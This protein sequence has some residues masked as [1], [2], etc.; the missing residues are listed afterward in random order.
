MASASEPPDDDFGVR[1]EWPG[2]R[3]S[4]PFIAPVSSDSATIDDDEDLVSGAKPRLVSARP[5]PPAPPDPTT[6][7]SFV[8][9]LE[10]L[11]TPRL[12]ESAS[13]VAML[14]A[15]VGRVD[16]LTAATLTFRE[17]AAQRVQHQASHVENLIGD[18]STDL[19]AGQ[20]RQDG[21]LREV[22]S[23][24]EQVVASQDRLAE[25][26]DDL[27]YRLATLTEETAAG[28]ARVA[29]D[30]QAIRRRTPIRARTGSSTADDV[31]AMADASSAAGD[32][33]LHGGDARSARP[34]TRRRATPTK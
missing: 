9:V 13:A 26:V 33:A 5:A 1:L 17:V 3:T 31:G 22:R 10:A 16:A 19:R 29:A 11:E 2:D 20:S 6:Q 18:L 15:V 24:L 21:L 7:A 34:R 27:G 30:L 12:P 14:A 32:E 4:E 28:L 8:S 23:A 25:I